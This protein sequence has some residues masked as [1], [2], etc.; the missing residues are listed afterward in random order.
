MRSLRLILTNPRY[1]GPAW[2]FASLNILFGTWAIYIPVVKE[3]LEIDKATLGIALFFLSL[4]VFTV[5]PVASRIVNFLGVGRATWIGILLLCFTALFPLMANSFITLALAL[6]FFGS[7]NGF[8]DISMNTLVTEIE[9]EDKQKFMSASHGFFSLGG[10]LA[11][12]GSF[13]IL[14]FESRML[15]MLAAVFLVLS[16]NLIFHK[17]YRHIR[18]APIEKEPF[19][20]RNFKPLLLLGIVSFVVMGSEGAIVDWSGLFLKEVTLAPETLWGAGFLGFQ[21][22]MTLGRFLGD[23]ISA[24]IGSVKIVA[25]G[26]SIAILGYLCVLLA[27]TYLAIVGFALTGLGFSVIIPELFRIGG[28]VKGVESSQG[29]AFIAGTGY[30]GFLVGPVI[31]GFLAEQFSLN[32]SF[33]VLLGCVILVLGTTVLLRRSRVKQS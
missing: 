15:H 5:F 33:T 18:A 23:A 13:L 16:I 3:D 31:L 4:G 21:I 24:R 12:L 30:S 20:L 26:A 32:T 22:T 7:A 14:V 29:V 6:F 2:A 17:R 1:F 25:L 11:G 8:L 28:N 9:K 27:S 19:K 10:V